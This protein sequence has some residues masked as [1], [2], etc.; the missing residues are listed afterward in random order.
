MRKWSLFFTLKVMFSR[1]NIALIILIGLLSMKGALVVPELL[2]RLALEAKKSCGALVRPHL[3][4]LKGSE[5][6]PLEYRIQN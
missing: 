6:F 3:H 4:K 1:N 5:A 2:E